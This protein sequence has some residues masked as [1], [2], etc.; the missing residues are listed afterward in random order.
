MKFQRDYGNRLQAFC[1]KHSIRYIEVRAPGKHLWLQRYWSGDDY[2][3]FDA[4]YLLLFAGM[5]IFISP[6]TQ[7]NAYESKTI[8]L[9]EPDFHAVTGLEGPGKWTITCPNHQ[10]ARKQGRHMDPGGI[11]MFLCEYSIAQAMG[12]DIHTLFIPY[13]NKS[14]QFCERDQ[15]VVE[16]NKI[17]LPYGMSFNMC[18][19]YNEIPPKETIPPVTNLVYERIREGG[20][21]GLSWIR[22]EFQDRADYWPEGG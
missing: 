8:L 20:G 4:V 15:F 11:Q 22:D 5:G 18:L 7:D 10:W 2:R 3:D 13:E 6:S 9:L 12:M 1:K 16:N 21:L 19:R 17:N 14:G